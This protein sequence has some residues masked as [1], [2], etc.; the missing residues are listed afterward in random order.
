MRPLIADTPSVAGTAGANK[1]RTVAATLAER[2]QEE[3]L[4]L[5]TVDLNRI[6][7]VML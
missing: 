3:L 6:R 1:A 4:S 5:M 2:D 7:S